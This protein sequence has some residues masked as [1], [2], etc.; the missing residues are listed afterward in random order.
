M[1]TVQVLRPSAGNEGDYP[2][3]IATTM[4]N[5]QIGDQVLTGRNQYEK[6]Y[7]FGHYHT[8]KRAE[9][10]QIHSEGARVPLEVTA[11]HL[12]FLHDDPIPVPAKSIQVGNTLHLQDGGSSKVTK[13]TKVRRNGI[14]APLTTGG[15]L[16]V[17]EVKASSYISF[18]HGEIPSRVLSPFSDHDIIHFSLAPYRLLCYGISTKFCRQS[19]YHD[20]GMPVYV[21]YGLQLLSFLFDRTHDSDSSQQ[22]SSIGWL[23]MIALRWI[24]FMVVFGF[25]GIFRTLEV[26]F[27]ASNAPLV[28][29][30]L[31]IKLFSYNRNHSRKTPT[32]TF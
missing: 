18:G 29:L 9:F 10:F 2:V 32:H 27:G 13:I 1:A 8:T 17:D 5:L 20:N 11:E 28:L 4:K 26:F 30:V 21:H 15:T 23:M 3:V 16:I 25:L 7:S 22:E 19:F 24:V 12:V 14:Y 6:I 31:A